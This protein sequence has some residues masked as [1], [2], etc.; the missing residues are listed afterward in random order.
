MGL[1]QGAAL[2][3]MIC[4]DSVVYNT[5]AKVSDADNSLSYDRLFPPELGTFKFAILC[6]GFCSQSSAH[7][8]VYDKINEICNLGKEESLEE[9]T[10]PVLHV[11][12]SK[13][14]V[15]KKLALS[16]PVTQQEDTAADKVSKPLAPKSGVG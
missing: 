7:V 13:G 1:S 11:V 6:S 14:K 12:G 3:G 5:C 16:N 10:I 4:L 15:I 8:K 9:C 2:A